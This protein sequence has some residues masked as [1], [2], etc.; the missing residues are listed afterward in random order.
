MLG[1]FLRMKK[2]ESTPPPPGAL[3]IKKIMESSRYNINRGRVGGF[4]VST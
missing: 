1:P 3:V 2:N 4:G